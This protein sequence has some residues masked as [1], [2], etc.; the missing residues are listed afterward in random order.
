MFKIRHIAIFTEDAKRLAGFYA[1][2]FG[3]KQTKEVPHSP[4][5]GYAVFMTDGYVE[6]ALIEPVNPAS[7]KG[8]N[9][10]GFTYDAVDRDA[11]LAKLKEYGIAPIKPPADRPYIEDAVKDIDGNKFDMSTTGLR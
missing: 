10:F 2:V 5:S 9:H 4:E 3:M 6:M 7:P 8:I 11:T 1:D